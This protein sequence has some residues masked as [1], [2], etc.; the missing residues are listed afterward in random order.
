VSHGESLR[1]LAALADDVRD[2]ECRV[3]LPM[4]CLAA[5]VLSPTELEDNNFGPEFLPDDLRF[6]LGAADERTAEFDRFAGPLNQ[7]HLI[8][9]DGIADI[10]GDFLDPKPIARADS[11]L[12]SACFEHRVHR[13]ALLMG[14]A[15]IT[16]RNGAESRAW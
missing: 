5:V 4:A 12:F 8:E 1:F 13:S 2:L 9:R 11:V 16:C 10:T 7:E 3:R 15:G 14:A 6:D